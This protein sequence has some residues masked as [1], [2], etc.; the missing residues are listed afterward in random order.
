M[1]GH[2]RIRTILREYQPEILYWEE[3]EKI[4]KIIEQ[5]KAE[6]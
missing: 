5:F 4:Q 3:Q 6:W 2:K 1:K